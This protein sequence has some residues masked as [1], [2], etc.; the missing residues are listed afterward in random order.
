MTY[1][2]LVMSVTKG[3]KTFMCFKFDSFTQRKSSY[4]YIWIKFFSSATS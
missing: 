3:S 4:P 2:P 1:N